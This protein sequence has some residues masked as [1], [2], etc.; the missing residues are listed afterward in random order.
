[1]SSTQILDPASEVVRTSNISIWSAKFSVQTVTNNKS[2]H[3]RFDSELD[4]KLNLNP[5]FLMRI[6]EANFL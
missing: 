1:M 5:H 6:Q 2:S 3:R 4:L